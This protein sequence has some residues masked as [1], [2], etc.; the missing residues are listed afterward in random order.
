[1]KSISQ[2]GQNRLTRILTGDKNQSPE[3]I[4]SLIK[5]DLKLLLEN[6]VELA[7]DIDIVME[8]F[9]DEF[10]FYVS[11]KANRIKNFGIMP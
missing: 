3:R 6:Y 1:M 7:D 2:V 8:A 9:E 11:F 5:S 10:S 4:C